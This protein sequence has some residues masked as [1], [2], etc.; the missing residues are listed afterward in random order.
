M[1]SDYDLD[2]PC[3]NLTLVHAAVS[4]T[5]EGYTNCPANGVLVVHTPPAA[6]RSHLARSPTS[7]H[8]INQ[9]TIRTDS[10]PRP[11]SCRTGPYSVARRSLLGMGRNSRRH[12]AMSYL[13]TSSTDVGSAAKAAAERKTANYSALSSSH[14]FIPVAVETLGPINQAGDS[15][16]AQVGKHLSSKSDD[17]RDTCFLFQR[18]SIIQRFNEIAFRSTFIEDSCHDE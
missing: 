10:K 14:I 16:L 9:G 15:F 17:P 3:A 13:P 5:Q 7:R 6:E 2:S 11:A 12:F 1:P 4:L 8:S 18:I